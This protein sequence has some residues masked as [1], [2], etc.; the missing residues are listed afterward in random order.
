VV[1]ERRR[2]LPVTDIKDRAIERRAKIVMVSPCA[3]A[4]NNRYNMVI[5]ISAFAPAH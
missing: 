4:R 3:T 5:C 2:R 1:G